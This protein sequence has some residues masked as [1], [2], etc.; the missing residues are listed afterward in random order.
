M[1]R[2][3]DTP[4]PAQTLKGMEIPPG[5]KGVT[6]KVRR[7]IARA[8]RGAGASHAARAGRNISIKVAAAFLLDPDPEAEEAKVHL[9]QKV[10]SE[11]A[12]VVLDPEAVAE[13]GRRAESRAHRAPA[14]KSRI[15]TRFD[16]H[17][18]SWRVPVWYRAMDTVY[19]PCRRMTG[20]LLS[21]VMIERWPL[22]CFVSALQL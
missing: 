8:G 14:C 6:T 17:I 9:D 1:V 13:D 20:T 3:G 4:A 19:P 15:I 11:R 21:Y 18:D 10:L 5:K 2:P 12:E 16:G 7:N 22:Q